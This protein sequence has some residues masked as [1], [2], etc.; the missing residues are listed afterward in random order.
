M[1]LAAEEGFWA[2]GRDAFRLAGGALACT[3]GSSERCH[4]QAPGPRLSPRLQSPAQDARAD[5]AGAGC[6][7]NQTCATALLTT[8]AYEG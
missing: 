3:R 1:R 4:T 8:T 5:H 2:Q 7:E 6:S